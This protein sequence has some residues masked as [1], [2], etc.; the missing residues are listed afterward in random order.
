MYY[1]I[2][3]HRNCTFIIINKLYKIN[4]A[5]INKFK[6]AQNNNKNSKAFFNN[7]DLQKYIDDVFLFINIIILHRK[8]D[9]IIF[10]YVIK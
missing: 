3:H 6:K 10:N 7:K 8:R 9:S 5:L 4:K 1:W 2:V